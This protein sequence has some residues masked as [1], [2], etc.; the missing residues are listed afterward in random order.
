MSMMERCVSSALCTMKG[1]GK[2][3]AIIHTKYEEALAE[4][5]VRSVLEELRDLD[6]D[7]LRAGTR[8]GYEITNGL[9]DPSALSVQISS[10][11]AH[12][13]RE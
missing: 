6:N 10:V 9:T 1:K 11:I 12:I 2:F 7:A 8:T 4:L 13:L 3:D 5:I